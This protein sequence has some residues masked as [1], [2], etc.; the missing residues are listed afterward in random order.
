MAGGLSLVRLPTLPYLVC[1][2]SSAY[3]SF[4]TFPDPSSSFKYGLRFARDDH[5]QKLPGKCSYRH[6]DEKSVSAC[7][8]D[9]A[10][11]GRV[12]F[13]TCPQPSHKYSTPTL[14]S[15]CSIQP[16]LLLVKSMTLQ[17]YHSIYVYTPETSSTGLGTFSSQSPRPP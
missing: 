9:S 2:Q 12:H 14:P 3:L 8:F 13:P 7:T 11:S 5:L 10:H 16:T 6:S 17:R 1:L 15:H 4:G